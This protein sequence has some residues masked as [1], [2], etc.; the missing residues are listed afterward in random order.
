MKPPD[1][2]LIQSFQLSNVQHY[3][4]YDVGL[5]EIEIGGVWAPTCNA[6]PTNSTPQ[7]ICQNLNYT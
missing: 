5:V 4:S 3:A 1:T 6:L 2:D 7:L